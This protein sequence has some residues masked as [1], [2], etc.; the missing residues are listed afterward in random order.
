MVNVDKNAF[1]IDRIR[2][3]GGSAW[4]QIPRQT[5]PEGKP[6]LWSCKQ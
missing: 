5:P 6:P 2:E 1:R 3:G 4:M